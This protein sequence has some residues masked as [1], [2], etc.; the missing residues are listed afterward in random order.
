MC[1]IFPK[2]TRCVTYFENPCYQNMQIGTLANSLDNLFEAT[3]EYEDSLATPRGTA[4]RRYNPN[5]DITSFFISLQCERNSNGA[6]SFDDLDIQNQSTSSELRGI[7]INQGA[8]DT[9]YNIGTNGKH[10][11]PPIQC[12]VHSTF[13]LFSPNNVGSCNYDTTHSFDEVIGQV[14][15]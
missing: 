7:S 2:D 10:P 11:P 4:A 8:V 15:A 14:T 5:T 9:Y 12:I 3:D 6:L 13:W 1:L